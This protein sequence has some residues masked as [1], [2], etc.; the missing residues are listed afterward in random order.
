MKDR[1]WGAYMPIMKGY[2]FFAGII[3]GNPDPDE[4]L[5]GV[6]V[7]EPTNA[8][9]VDAARCEVEAH[10]R[11]VLLRRETHAEK[12]AFAVAERARAQ[13]ER[14]AAQATRNAASKIYVQGVW[15]TYLATP[16]KDVRRFVR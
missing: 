1:A 3:N 11:E 16:T 10:R 14:R 9:L 6:K 15:M 4:R 2:W 5:Y 13:K 7:S 12:V 8:E